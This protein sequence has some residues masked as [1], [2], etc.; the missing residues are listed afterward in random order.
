MKKLLHKVFNRSTLKYLAAFLI[1]MLF[2]A[3]TNNTVDNDT[4]YVLTE[5]RYI[6]ENGVFY[7][8]VLSMHDGLNVVV[9]NYGFSVV[10]YWIFSLFGGGGLYVS[11]LLI[12]LLIC[13]LIYKICMLL[14]D[15]NKNLSLIIMVATDILLAGYF[16]CTRAQ[17]ISYVLFL[18]LIYILE[19]YVKKRETKVLF[20][21]PII[22]LLQINIHASLW[23]MI[24]LVMLTYII[25]SIKLPKLKLQGYKTWPLLVTTVVSALVGLINP[26]GIRM[27]TFMFLNYFDSVQKDF[28]AELQSFS[29]FSSTFCMA[30]YCS[31]VLVAML[32]VFAKDKN[33][34]ARHFLMFFG[35]LALGLNTIK[36]LSQFILVMF[37]PFAYLYKNFDIKKLIK[38]DILR[39]S[40]A[41]WGEIGIICASVLVVPLVSLS[42]ESVP[43]QKVAK[44]VDVIDEKVAE[45]AEP[46]TIYANYNI[47]GYFGFRGYKPYIDSRSEYYLKSVNGK[48]DIL[49]EHV[50][51]VEGRISCETLVEKY[52]FDLIF[53]DGKSDPFYDY[54][55]EMYEVIY[56]SN[57]EYHT[58][59]LRRIGI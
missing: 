30:V 46:Y 21:V 42:V 24:F 13:Y 3:L 41:F 19:L 1:P 36:G 15:K 47:G 10:F 5:G 40:F 38:R 9:Q 27:I 48:A 31:I 14:S 2:V 43:N 22:S 59:V 7:E 29:P 4:W 26:Y 34:K 32:Y 33:I 53:V 51:F 28:I 23:L 54:K 57:D 44:V 52:N 45:R 8:D 37:L 12:N 25:D 35:F 17:M 55:S 50:D 49:K 16:V 6:T 11:M 58:K 39:Q 20:L 56:E 18:L